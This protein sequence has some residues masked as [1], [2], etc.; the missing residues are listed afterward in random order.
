MARREGLRLGQ[1]AVRRPRVH[2]VFHQLLEAH[3]RVEHIAWGAREAGS[4]H[5]SRLAAREPRHHVVGEEGQRLRLQPAVLG[6]RRVGEGDGTEGRVDPG[7]T[8]A[9]AGDLDHARRGAERAGE[10]AF[11]RVVLRAG[12]AAGGH[13][14]RVV[15]HLP[16]QL[17]V[18]GPGDEAC[19]VEQVHLRVLQQPLQDRNLGRGQAA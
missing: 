13:E 1:H 5:A 7:Q 3:H 19:A 11:W 4:K 14:P 9:A 18:A 8:A 15:A 12:G 16:H 17:Q 10:G 6:G 2:L